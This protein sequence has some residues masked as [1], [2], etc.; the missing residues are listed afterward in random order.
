MNLLITGLSA[1]LFSFSFLFS[2]YLGFLILFFLFP[3]IHVLRNATRAQACYYGFTWGMIAYG[4][5]FIWLL[6]LL[7]R[8]SQATV[9]LA[10]I[11]YLGI[12]IYAS[13]TSAL[14]LFTTK[15]FKIHLFFTTIAYFLFISFHMF[16]FF[17]ECYPFM[18]PLIPLMEYVPSQV[19]FMPDKE[20]VEWG[21]Y[22]FIYLKPCEERDNKHLAS[23]E[24]YKK[25]RVINKACEKSC[26][27]ICLVGPET[28]YQFAPTKESLKSWASALGDKEL[29]LG[30]LR[31]HDS[32]RD[33]QHQTVY[34][35]STR[36]SPIIKSYDKCHC[37]P[38]AE[39]IPRLWKTKI[40]EDL[41]IGDHCSMSPG[42]CHQNKTF[43]I[44][45]NLIVR[46]LICSELFFLSTN[47]ILPDGADPQ[48]LVAFVND[49]WFCPY[50]RR[51][52]ALG[53]RFRALRLDASLLY[54]GHKSGS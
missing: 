5:H 2:K 26:A 43:S 25:I 6:D 42:L 20:C 48:L 52:L 44:S 14:W 22:K 4:L 10:I 46:P 50:F 8:K 23:R 19:V 24:I 31:N 9:V 7:I 35:I 36:E 38:F 16:W 49:S 11:I 28:T 37:V 13:L 53:A 18:N 32:L 27:K 40:S 34:Q 29:M 33:T 21:D 45:P 1:L 15:L 41:F 12:V 51:I 54:V 47:E 17:D 39:K 3:L 30:S